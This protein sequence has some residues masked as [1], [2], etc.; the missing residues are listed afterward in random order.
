[1]DSFKWISKFGLFLLQIFKS[2]ILF[3]IKNTITKQLLQHVNFLATLASATMHDYSGKIGLSEP[4][5]LLL[6]N[7]LKA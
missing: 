5:T 3:I 7:S 4:N 1:M 2:I 6:P